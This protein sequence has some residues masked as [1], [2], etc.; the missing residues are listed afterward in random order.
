[1]AQNDLILWTLYYNPKDFPAKYVARRFIGLDPQS[2][3]IL[4]DTLQQVR[5]ALPSSVFL[6]LPRV[7]QDDP[8]IVEVWL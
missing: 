6:C 1:M 3:V 2:D 4:G 7:E 8:A 5:E